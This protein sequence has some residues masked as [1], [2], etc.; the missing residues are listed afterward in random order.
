[1]VKDKK[2]IIILS[3]V[4]IIVL[5]SLFLVYIFLLRP[6]LN[7]LVVRGQNQGVQYAVYAI[8]QQASGCNIVPLFI[9]NSTNNQTINMVAVDCLPASCL[10]PAST[11]P[12]SANQTNVQK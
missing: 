11:Q 4:L 8:A 10:Q 7:G 12:A 3:L 2:N 5:L 9:G 1:M 6:A